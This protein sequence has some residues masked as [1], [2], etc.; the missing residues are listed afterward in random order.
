M[1]EG[2]KLLREATAGFEEKNDA[3]VTVAPGVAGSGVEVELSSPVML[4]FGKHIK[5]L[6]ADT[7]AA[8][9]YKDVKVT[10][11]DKGAWDYT[12]NARIVAALERGA[13]NA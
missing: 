7:V 11:K 10:I 2:K 4:H 3:L 5:A 9:G 1:G 13:K 12:L 6:A 8:V